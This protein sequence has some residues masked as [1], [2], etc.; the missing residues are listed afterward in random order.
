MLIDEPRLPPQFVDGLHELQAV[1]HFDYA[2]FFEVGLLQR[3]EKTTTAY[4]MIS[5]VMLQGV[6]TM[7]IFIELNVGT[8]VKSEGFNTWGRMVKVAQFSSDTKAGKI[9]SDPLPQ[10]ERCLAMHTGYIGHN[11]TL[12]DQSLLHE[13]PIIISF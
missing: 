7:A 1:A 13:I 9:R 8:H 6:D 3:E 10:E 4:G 5:E 2:H 11:S 12:I